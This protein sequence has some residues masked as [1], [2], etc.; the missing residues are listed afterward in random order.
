MLEGRLI[1]DNWTDKNGQNRSKHS[2]RVDT[3]KMLGS[4]E[5]SID[6]IGNQTMSTQKETS[7]YNPSNYQPAVERKE[8]DLDMIDDIEEP[9]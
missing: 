6:N 2:L 3:M 8:V 1:L 7:N 5:N 4:N 9:F